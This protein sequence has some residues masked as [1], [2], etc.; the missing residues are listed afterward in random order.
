MK[1]PTTDLKNRYYF[2]SKIDDT[3]S[4][5][6]KISDEQDSDNCGVHF[7]TYITTPREVNRG[8]SYLDLHGDRQQVVYTDTYNVSTGEIDVEECSAVF[9]CIV[10]EYKENLR[11][12]ETKRAYFWL[13]YLIQDDDTVLKRGNNSFTF[14]FNTKHSGYKNFSGTYCDYYLQLALS[15]MAEMLLVYNFEEVKKKFPDFLFAEKNDKINI[16]GKQVYFKKAFKVSNG[17]EDVVN[18]KLIEMEDVYLNYADVC[19]RMINEYADKLVNRFIDLNS[20]TSVSDI[21]SAPSAGLFDEIY[22]Y[23]PC[24]RHPGNMNF[25]VNGDNRVTAA[26]ITC[27]YNYLLGNIDI[28]L[29]RYQKCLTTCNEG[30][31]EIMSV[32]YTT[33]DRLIEEMEDPD[34]VLPEEYRE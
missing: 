14:K 3:K 5:V 18:G 9:P 16:N 10:I 34:W 26:D 28:D 2:L 22:Q 13:D 17:V 20:G 11:D 29:G 1:H 31:P 7:V 12:E 21:M 23:L 32:L 6:Y 25:D 27:L 15:E 8:Q 30:L 4:M 33:R 19:C 24:L